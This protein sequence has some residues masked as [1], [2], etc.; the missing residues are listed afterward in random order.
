MA[1]SWTQTSCQTLIFLTECQP[2]HWIFSTQ[3]PWL[4]F[5]IGDIIYT[6]ALEH[7]C[8]LA[9]SNVQLRQ[10]HEL[11]SQS[12]LFIPPCVLGSLF[13]QLQW[14]ENRPHCLNSSKKYFHLIRFP[15]ADLRNHD[16]NKTLLQL[17]SPISSVVTSLCYWMFLMGTVVWF[18]SWDL[19]KV[20]LSGSQFLICK[21]WGISTQEAGFLWGLEVDT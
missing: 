16:T 14:S 15:E 12:Y 21:V 2:W 13:S 3:N 7:L 9:L 19:E 10:F 4:I 17:H 18:S 5:S 20:H 11:T 8:C 1:L 6:Q